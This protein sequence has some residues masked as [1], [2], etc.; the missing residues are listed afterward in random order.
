MKKQTEVYDSRLL[1][2]F[3]VAGM[4]H[5]EGATVLDQLKAGKKLKLKYERNNP[6][7][8][9]AVA[10]YYKGTKLGYVPRDHNYLPAK[11]MRFGHKGILEA[12]IIKVDKKANT[13]NQVRVG[14]YLVD[15]R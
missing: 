10:I 2:D 14:I 13:W 1:V 8:T 5:W 15:N 3:Y 9:N 11:L 6:Y 7:D 4:R 12:R